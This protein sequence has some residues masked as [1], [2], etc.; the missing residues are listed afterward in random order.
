M[1]ARIFARD[2]D[3]QLECVDE[4]K[5]R[6]LLRRS[7]GDEQVAA[8]ERPPAVDLIDA[9][10]GPGH[11][12]AAL[13]ALQ[14]GIDVLLQ[15]SINL[16]ESSVS[17][18]VLARIEL[19]DPLGRG[20]APRAI[21]AARLPMRA[22]R[23]G[24]EDAA[25]RTMSA[26]DHLANGYL[27]LA[28]EANAATVDE[29]KACRFTPERLLDP[30]WT[31]VPQVR[32]GLDELTRSGGPIA[33]TLLAFELTDAFL[34]YARAAVV[35]ETRKFRDAIVHRERPS[36]REVPGF[37]RV[38]GWREGKISFDQPPSQEELDELPTIGERR[39]L[40]AASIEET[41]AFAEASWALAVRFLRSV[42]VLVTRPTKDTVSVTTTYQLGLPDPGRP[43]PIARENR[44]PGKF[45]R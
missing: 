18:A 35:R 38:T 19:A 24:V 40:V 30:H 31:G 8:L 10:L 41:F 11:A 14:E 23:F 5:R 42:D 36:Y 3:R 22:A 25:V 32:E 12:R 7:L 39:S 37:G 20:T 33:S 43:V 9:A 6:E 1:P 44:D 45:L 21:D 27:R 17:E 2:Q 4:V 34:G 28:W 13:V 29:L 15:A 16:V 26:G